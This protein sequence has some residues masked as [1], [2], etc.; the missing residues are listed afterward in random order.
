MQIG[1][2]IVKNRMEVPQKIRNRSSDPAI[3]LLGMHLKETV[4]VLGRDMHSHVHCGG[5]HHSQETDNILVL[6][7]HFFILLFFLFLFVSVFF[8][9]Y[10]VFF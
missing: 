9:L 2:V 10:F 6:F 1:T 8:F 4:S 7:F 5:L 3:P